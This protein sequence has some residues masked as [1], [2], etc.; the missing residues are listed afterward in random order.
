MNGEDEQGVV[1][2]PLPGS[3]IWGSEQGIDLGSIEKGHQIAV[4]ALLWNR[5]DPLNE[6]AQR[7]LAHRGEAEEG[8]YGGEPGIAGTRAVTSLLLEVVEEVG[9]EGCIQIGE[10]ELGRRLAECQVQA[11]VND[12]CVDILVSDGIVGT[13]GAELLRGER[14][15]P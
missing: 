11:T 6:V 5:Q 4:E 12:E 10:E 15:Q 2:S 8:A 1:T 9:N 7:G 13:S 3:V 14:C